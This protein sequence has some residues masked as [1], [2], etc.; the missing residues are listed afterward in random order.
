LAREIASA[1][2]HAHTS[3]PHPHALITQAELRRHVRAL[4]AERAPALAVVTAH[5]LVPH[6]SLSPT[7]PIG[8]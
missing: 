7:P 5:E 8:P 6:L 3:T 2:E 4:V 1:I